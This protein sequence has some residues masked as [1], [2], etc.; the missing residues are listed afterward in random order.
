MSLPKIVAII[1]TYHPQW[2]ELQK[3]LFAALPQFDQIIMIDNGSTLDQ[4][5]SIADF[6]KD[7]P[8]QLLSLIHI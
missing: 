8:I 7:R 2:S 4:I 1:V 5:Q 6:A 3:L